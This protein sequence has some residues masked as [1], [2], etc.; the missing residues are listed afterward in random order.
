MTCFP[1]I[2]SAETVSHLRRIDLQDGGI[3]CPLFQEAIHLWLWQLHDGEGLRR[4]CGIDLQGAPAMRRIPDLIS[5]R[6]RPQT[7]SKTIQLL[8]KFDFFGCDYCPTRV[9]GTAA[10]YVCK[11]CHQLY[12]C[13]MSQKAKSHLGTPQV[14]SRLDWR[15]VA[16]RRL[17]LW[18]G[19]V[20]GG[21]DLRQ[22]G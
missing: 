3:C 4:R 20:K 7:T 5:R 15:Q 14:P 1:L 2:T 6:K 12:S 9:P 21:R 16:Q 22:R 10:W 13:L 17:G 11:L 19:V 8:Q 18:Q